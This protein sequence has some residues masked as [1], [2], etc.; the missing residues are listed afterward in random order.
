MD[1]AA[2]ESESINPGQQRMDPGLFKMDRL[3]AYG[4]N[5]LAQFRV[6]DAITNFIAI[7]RFTKAR[8]AFRTQRDLFRIT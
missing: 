4:I 8:C 5:D 7:V 2:M 3:Q 6:A 1:Y